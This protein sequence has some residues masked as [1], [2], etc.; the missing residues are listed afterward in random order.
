MAVYSDDLAPI[1]AELGPL[2]VERASHVE[3]DNTHAQWGVWSQAG[4][5]TGRRFSTRAE[6]LAWEV[7]H[8]FTLLDSPRDGAEEVKP[9]FFPT[10]GTKP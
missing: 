4:R 8:I 1:L 5:D 3:F 9:T 7:A 2:H 10:G 6:A